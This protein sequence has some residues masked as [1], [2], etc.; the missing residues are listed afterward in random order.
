M[1]MVGALT[2]MHAKYLQAKESYEESALEDERESPEDSSWRI[3]SDKNWNL[4]I[5]TRA[6]HEN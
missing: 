2:Y 5:F 3:V 6:N 4:E 1:N